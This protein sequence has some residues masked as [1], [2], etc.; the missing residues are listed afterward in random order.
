M[1]KLIEFFNNKFAII[2]II[3]LIVILV[4]FIILFNI[5]EKKYNKYIKKVNELDKEKVR[6]VHTSIDAELSKLNKV[7]KDKV[8]MIVLSEWTEQWHDMKSVNVREISDILLKTESKIEKKRFKGIEDELKLCEVIIED[9]RID[10]N[11]LHSE[12]N[13]LV[14]KE[15]DIRNKT[16]KLKMDI[17]EVKQQYVE[18]EAVLNYMQVELDDK[19]NDMTLK[20]TD[21]ENIIAVNNYD[22]ANDTIEDIAADVK[23]FKVLV[24]KLPDLII[25]IKQII[26][27]KISS[28]ESI[29]NKCIDKGIYLKHLD[30]EGKISS[31][32][33]MS[34][35]IVAKMKKL[36]FSDI[37]AEIDALVEF[38][39]NIQ[40][41]LEGESK[42]FYIFQDN[43]SELNDIINDVADYVTVLKTEIE[44]VKVLYELNDFD[45]ESYNVF[46]GKIEQI[47]KTY[48]NLTLEPK[49]GEYYFELNEH[50][51]NLINRTKTVIEEVR[52]G[53][54]KVLRLR[55]DEQRAREQIVEIQYLVDQSRKL[56]RNS[57]IPVVPSE[58]R[59]YV[60]DA[61]DGIL[62]IV[63]EL[64]KT[65]IVVETLNIRVDTS[66]EL[67]YKLYNNTKI[68]IKEAMLAEVSIMYGNRY[69]SSFSNVSK[70][71]NIAEK[72][73]FD[74]KYHDCLNTVVNVLEKTEPGIYAQLKKYFERGGFEDEAH[75]SR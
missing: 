61:K 21:L 9:F 45:E 70:D 5:R 31:V 35:E 51:V 26:P 12:I 69:R 47:I 8:L 73:F 59:T 52:D 6:I 41:I 56:M 66:L 49:V 33:V 53:T 68:I 65:P 19:L 60:A 7:I 48:D 67:A 50:V 63:D 15:D 1:D 55:A 22:L 44:K 3:I 11:N 39:D 38:S 57:K 30:F 29:Y 16:T 23:V 40:E 74:G 20:I 37:E 14:R 32:K 54:E 62:Y 75:I 28:L 17:R 24:E 46:E 42:N 27:R 13:A 64:E 10:T 43:V 18:K 4:V 58:Y 34:D 36:N 72:L 25:I 2:I 71:L